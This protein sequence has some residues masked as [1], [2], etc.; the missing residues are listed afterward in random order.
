MED[1]FKKTLKS[2]DELQ[3]ELY[4]W[5]DEYHQPLV[6][7]SSKLLHEN[8]PLSKFFRYEFIWEVPIYIIDF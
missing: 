4:D 7:L 3:K 1:I 6:K 2:W 5:C 8:D